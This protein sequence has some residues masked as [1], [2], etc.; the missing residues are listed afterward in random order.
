[1]MPDRPESSKVTSLGS[2]R[3]RL[4]SLLVAIFLAYVVPSAV[5]LRS[6]E[7]GWLGEHAC[8][9]ERIHLSRSAKD[10]CL[11]LDAFVKRAHEAVAAASTPQERID[12]LNRFFFQGEGMRVTADLSSADH[13]L[14]ST[15]LAEKRGY[16]VGL[17]LLYLIIAENFDLPI[18]GVATPK[19]IFVR[20][21][22]GTLRRNI[23]LFQEGRAVPDEDYIREQKI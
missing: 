3:G 23:E 9:L 12:R 20:W 19:H 22:D 7:H 5:C 17:A 4:R 10:P 11:E 18:H 15:V 16:C 14:P 6:A 21:D 2:T 13:L 8:Q 1:M